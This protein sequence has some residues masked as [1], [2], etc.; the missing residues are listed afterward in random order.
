[1]LSEEAI[2]PRKRLTTFRVDQELRDALNDALARDG[3][4]ERRKSHWLRQAIQAFVIADPGLATVGAGEKLK[5]FTLAERILMDDDTSTAIDE[6]IRII[7]R[8]DYRTDGLQASIIRA[9]IRHAAAHGSEKPK[10]HPSST[11]QTSES[12]GARRTRLAKSIG[13]S[14]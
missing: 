10:H 9:A 13:K 8:S 7:R 6:A 3:I 1:M 2:T 4:S 11:R 5:R 14:V 12:G